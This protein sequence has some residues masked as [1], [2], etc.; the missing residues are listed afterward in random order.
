[1]G[2]PEPIDFGIL[3][4]AGFPLE[5]YETGQKIFVAE[6]PAACLYVVKS[7]RIEIVSYVT[8]LD[9]VGPHDIFG[10]MSLIDGGVRSATAVAAEPS[11]VAPVNREAFIYLVQRN[12]DFAL[13][14]MR[15]LVK[16]IR[17]MN[18]SL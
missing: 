5:T 13:Q 4:D 14:V 7:G 10:E 1:M 9:S 17:G 11:I 2:D 8:V 12:P 15:V 16:R 18:E 6:D 3:A